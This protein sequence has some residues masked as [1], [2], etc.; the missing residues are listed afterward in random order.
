[1]TSHTSNKKVVDGKVV[2]Y[3][4]FRYKCASGQNATGKCRAWTF[5][6][7][8]L[9]DV[10][11]RLA[12]NHIFRPMGKASDFDLRLKGLE[13]NLA[14]KQT[15]I[16]NLITLAKQGIAPKSVLAEIT[17][18]ET[19]IDQLNKAIDTAKLNKQSE[20]TEV[21]EWGEVDERVLDYNQH[22][23]RQSL[24]ER[25]H[26]SVKQV[27]CQQVRSRLVKFTITFINDI[28]IVAY[29]TPKTLVFDGL[30]WAKLGDFYK[31]PVA[32]SVADKF[33]YRITGKDT[34]FDKGLLKEELGDLAQFVIEPP[35]ENIGVNDS[36]TNHIKLV[37]M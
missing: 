11:V 23:L 6:A 8:W 1:M 35:V 30:A 12:A 19:D 15:S 21:V 13:A 34:A 3:D 18:L 26:L 29:R 32:V 16:D 27:I 31:S 7:L 17:Q 2:K 25:I 36:Y 24:K 9:D 5:N 37:I 4:K 28:T 33:K 22:S 14:E 20:L 10:V